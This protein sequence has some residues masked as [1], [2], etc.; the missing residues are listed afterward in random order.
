MTTPHDH[1]QCCPILKAIIWGIVEERRA[2][3]AN[4]RRV[5]RHYSEIVADLDGDMLALRVDLQRERA[6]TAALRARLGLPAVRPVLRER[7]PSMRHWLA[8]RLR[9]RLRH[10]FTTGGLA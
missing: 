1:A 4:L 2:L 3:E 9:A 5:M 6:E 7:G 8:R 10:R